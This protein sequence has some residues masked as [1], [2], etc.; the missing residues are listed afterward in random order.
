VLQVREALGDGAGDKA[1]EGYFGPTTVGETLA[2]FYGFDLIVHRWDV[3]RATGADLRFT[4]EEMDALEASIAQF[5]DLMYAEGICATAREVG[6][7][8]DRQERLLALTGRATR[9]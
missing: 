7:G 3:G 8:A 4:D 9:T 2:T 6:E 1:I 5:G